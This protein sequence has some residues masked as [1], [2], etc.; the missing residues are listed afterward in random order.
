MSIFHIRVSKERTRTLEIFCGGEG[1][2]FMHWNSAF[3]TSARR[4]YIIQQPQLSRNTPFLPHKTTKDFPLLHACHSSSV[5][6]HQKP[7]SKSGGRHDEAFAELDRGCGSSRGHGNYTA[8]APYSFL[9]S[10]E[11]KVMMEEG[12]FLCHF[13]F[14]TRK[15]LN[16]YIT[17]KIFFYHMHGKRK[18]EGK[19][20]TR[21]PGPVLLPQFPPLLY[22]TYTPIPFLSPYPL[23]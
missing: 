13:C 20:A 11:G 6:H 9:T 23:R 4:C 3:L 19:R 17:P 18:L 14:L 7:S 16:L 21:K 12:K 5:L 2:D 15:W 1:V 22:P 10:A 8:L